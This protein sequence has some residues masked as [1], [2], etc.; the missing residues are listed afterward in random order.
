VGGE[1]L[2]RSYAVLRRGGTLISIVDPTSPGEC[3]NRGLSCP[4]EA[5]R[6]GSGVPLDEIRKLA[7]AGK[8]RLNVDRTYPLAQAAQAQELNRKGRTRGKIVLNVG[9]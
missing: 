7:E 5:P 8:F 6:D 4:D 9:G 3:T 1:T 2:Q